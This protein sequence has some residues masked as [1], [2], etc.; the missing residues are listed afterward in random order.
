MNFRECSTNLI[1][2]HHTFRDAYNT[3]DTRETLE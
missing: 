1:V 3:K 2:A